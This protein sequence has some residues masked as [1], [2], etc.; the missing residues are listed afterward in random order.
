MKTFAGKR[1]SRSGKFMKVEAAFFVCSIMPLFLMG[2]CFGAD[3]YV[4]PDGDDGNPGLRYRPFRTI[5][6][7]V[8]SVQ[9]GDTVLIRKGIYRESVKIKTDGR[10]DARIII[11]N[12]P[13]EKPVIDGSEPITGWRRCTSA[14]DCD[15]NDH[16]ANIYYAYAPAGADPFTANLH[17]DDEMLAIAQGPN[18]SD[19]FYMDDLSDYLEVSPAD[20]TNSTIVDP[21]LQALGGEELIGA[22]IAVWAQGNTVFFRTVTAYY[23]FQKKI[24]FEQI[25]GKGVYKDRDSY[26]SIINSNTTGVL[27]RPGEYAFSKTPEPDGRHKVYVWPLNNRNLEAGGEVTASLRDKLVYVGASYITLEGL[28]IQKGIDKV[29]CTNWG[30]TEGNVFRNLEIRNCRTDGG[31]DNSMFVFKSSDL[32]VENNYLHHNAGHSRG[33]VVSYGTGLEITRN[34]IEKVTGTA[35]FLQHANYGQITHNSVR[36]CNGVHSNGISTYSGCDNMLV[37]SNRVVASNIAYTMNNSSNIAVYNN[38]FDG[39]DE[40]RNVAANWGGESG[41][42]LFLNNTII[43]SSSNF[44]LL[45]RGAE[46]GVVANNILEGGGGGIRKHNIYTALS[47]RQSSASGWFLEEGE[48]VELNPSLVFSGTA[49]F[50]PKAGGP[51]HD[52]GMD[53]AAY[54]KK[55]RVDFP[56]YDFDKDLAGNPRKAGESVDIGCYERQAKGGETDPNNPGSVGGMDF[57]N[58]SI[59]SSHYGSTNCAAL[60]N[61]GGLDADHD[62]DVDMVDYVIFSAYWMDDSY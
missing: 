33:I 42:I 51:A 35:I 62:G 9:P 4:S 11:K 48:M 30:P 6:R 29:V 36:F 34:T 39:A 12:Y 19:P 57:H 43:G 50:T 27:D 56:E 52:A 18:P 17:Q 55:L 32:L 24:V 58:L 60:G 28:T 15:G 37:A 1:W 2:R 25:G 49:D 20:I 23:P 3:Y 22:T 44:A 10:A 54:L 31:A 40:T 7:A 41:D 59:F 14:R 38:F 45:I 53:L 21:R 13:G 61:C 5:S 47:W 46:E 26:Y 8:S 16:W